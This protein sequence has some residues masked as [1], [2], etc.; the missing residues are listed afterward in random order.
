MQQQTFERCTYILLPLL[1]DSMDA[2]RLFNC[3]IPLTHSSHAIYSLVNIS[4][5]MQIDS[6]SPIDTEMPLRYDG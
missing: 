6:L 4:S 5:C 2:M 1:T 3:N